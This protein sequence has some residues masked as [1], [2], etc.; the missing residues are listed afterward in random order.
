MSRLILSELEP[1]I[2]TLHIYT[3]V[4]C[5]HRNDFESALVEFEMSL[6]LDENPYARFNRANALLALGRYE[7]GFRDWNVCRQI[8]R[9]ELGE[10]AKRWYFAE[11]RPIWRGEP[12]VPVII[13]H[14]HGFG[15]AIQLM[16]FVPAVKALAQSVVLDVPKPLERLA[17][18]LALLADDDSEGYLAPWFDMVALQGPTPATIPPPPYLKPDPALILEWAN[19]IGNGGR[20]RVGVAW[21]VK[22]TSDHEHPNAKREIPF[23]QFLELLPFD[24]ELYSLQIQD[25][26][27][28]R[29]YGLHAPAF[30]D[31]ADVAALASL[32][33]AVVS[34]DTACL[35]LAGA[36]GHPNVYGLLP[37][38]AT[39]RWLNGNVWYPN[40]K[41]CKQTTPGD[42]PSAFAQIH[43]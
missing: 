33:D 24:G 4:D 41:L 19:R 43:A 39:W 1:D 16:R 37:Y 42:W 12:D 35:H 26:E 14:E 25:R 32:M 6:A 20:R 17:A 21:S 27:R 28:A 15:D 13:V 36:I 30:D 2:A 22:L 5:F 31:F 38:A 18:Q 40:M 11:R 10:R 9:C 7:E 34:V 23:E 29:A 8:Y 3:G